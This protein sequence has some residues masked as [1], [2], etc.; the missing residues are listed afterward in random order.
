MTVTIA[1]TTDTEEQVAE[2]NTAANEETPAGDLSSQQAGGVP[3]DSET[4]DESGETDV[5]AA[6]SDEASSEEV[7]DDASESNEPVEASSDEGDTESADEPKRKRRRRGRSYRDRASQLA[8]EKAAEQARADRLENEIRTLRAQQAQRPVAETD[9]G[10]SDDE[11]QP[12][13]QASESAPAPKDGKPDQDKFE[14]YEEYAEALMDWKVDQR[15][16][17]QESEHRVRIEQDQAQKAHESS[18]ATLHE[19]IDTFREANPDFDAV[20]EKGKDLPMTRPMQ[21]SVLNSDLGPALMYHLS[22]NPEEC[23]RISQLHPMAAI[24]EM[25]KLEARLEDVSTGP[26]SSTHSVTKAPKPIKPVGGGATASTTR[27]DDLPYQ[28]FKRQREIQLGI[29]ER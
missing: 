21:D 7:S 19:R 18:V 29:R 2:L 8:R 10:T 12:E 13:V 23:D 20:I 28:E 24:K 5:V 6:E 25:G 9:Q 17:A 11:A 1:S 15:M 14:T 27:L 22:K 26:S 4:S 16:V 3:N